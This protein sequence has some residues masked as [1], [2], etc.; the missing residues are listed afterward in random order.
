MDEIYFPSDDSYLLLDVLKKQIPSLIKKN[1]NLNVLEIGCGSGINLKSLLELG[2]KK[3]NILSCDINPFAVSCC[4]KLGFK[5][6]KS[7]LFEKINGKFDLIIFNPPYLPEDKREPASSKIS[8]TGGKNGSE[9]TNKFIKL[10]R[11]YLNKKGMIFLVISSL[12]GKIKFLNYRKTLLSEKKL[13]FESI[14]V[15]KLNNIFK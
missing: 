2:V 4:R 1:S 15:F 11:K 5:C 6:L 13:F 10:S 7:D 12:T 3:E 14:Y 8:T 9:I